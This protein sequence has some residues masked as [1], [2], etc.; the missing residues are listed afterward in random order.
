MHLSST[1]I[2]RYGNG[3]YYILWLLLNMP[4]KNLNY[5]S[6]LKYIA[7][8]WDSWGHDSNL[9]VISLAI[10]F[11]LVSR[12]I[13]DSDYR[14]LIQLIYTYSNCDEYH[15]SSVRQD[16]M[17]MYIICSVTVGLMIQLEIGVKIVRTNSSMGNYLLS[18]PT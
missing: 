3:G 8:T 6:I 14:P 7:Q 9:L 5:L 11:R 10:R 13:C 2:Y 18:I 16:E 12:V 1:T 15:I 17:R 4:T